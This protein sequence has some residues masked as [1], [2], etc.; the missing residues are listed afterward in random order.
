MLKKEK[1]FTNEEIIKAIIKKY[2]SVEAYAKQK[3]VQAE[4]MY[5]RIG[6]QTDKFMFELERDNIT[7]EKLD[8][9]ITVKDAEVS[10]ILGSGK[11]QTV[12]K[13]DCSE[14]KTENIY[15]KKL[16]EEKDSQIKLLREMIES[17][18]GKQA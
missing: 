3:G 7:I 13:D 2:G 14:I 16:L 10:G 12:I 5:Q 4:S 11:F 17:Y 8:K 6:R 1:I 18:K 15:L 9:S